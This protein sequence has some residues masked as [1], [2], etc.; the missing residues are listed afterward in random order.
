MDTE[1]DARARGRRAGVGGVGGG[2]GGGQRI[3][4][5]DPASEYGGLVLG[6]D[7]APA[8]VSLVQE[9][10]GAFQGVHVC[11]HLQGVNL[12]GEEGGRGRGGHE[13]GVSAGLPSH[14][15]KSSARTRA[16]GLEVQSSD[17]GTITDTWGSIHHDMD[18]T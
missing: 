4:C 5:G 13:T 8:G 12:P 6:A 2:G 11:V 15:D 18:D 3:G 16:R 10:V 14:T 1:L 17:H 7:G 9:P